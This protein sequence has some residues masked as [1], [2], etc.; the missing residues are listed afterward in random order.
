[1][2]FNSYSF[3]FLFL[4]IAFFGTFWLG[5]IGRR[6]AAIWLGLASLAFY[7]A[8]NYRFVAVL[9]ASIAFN[10]GAGRWIEH[11]RE[12]GGG[13]PGTLS[14]AAPLAANLLVLGYFKYANFFAAT[15]NSILGHRLPELNIVLPLGISFFTFTQIAYL[16]DVYRGI[17]FRYAF[18][19]YLLFVTW[20]PHLI[21][22]PILHH[23]QMTPQFSNPAT[24]RVN[25]ANATVGVS[26][27]VLGLAKKVLIADTLSDYVDNIFSAANLGQAPMLIEAWFGALAYSLQL[28]F[29]FSGYCD[30]AIG[31]S[32][33]FNVRLPANFDS[34]YRASS[35]IDFWR[36][37][38]MTL[39][40]FLRDYL[41]FP[42]GGNRKGTARR[43][44]NLMI[45]MLLGGLWHG[46]SWTFVAWGG[47]HGVYLCVNHG[48]RE[49]KN[50]LGFGFGGMIPSFLAR[51]LTF[52]AVVFAWVLFRAENFPAAEMIMA[53]MTGMNGMLTD[54]MREFLAHWRMGDGDAFKSL[55][56]LFLPAMQRSPVDPREGVITLILGLALVWLCPNV[57]QMMRKHRP[58]WDDLEQTPSPQG[59]KRVSKWLE[60]KPLP[61]HAA[62]LGLLLFWCLISLSKVTQF[63]YWQ[64]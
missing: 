63:L 16:V 6:P 62:A 8:W 44:L 22:G 27:F 13:H 53:G 4:P 18:I 23:Q 41:Y 1:M 55:F 28:Y 3:I 5:R 35:I 17:A 50:R 10:Y 15:V 38:H 37:W 31:A 56:K 43:Y 11:R 45:T 19:D 25:A 9:L 29:D 14:L 7:A 64:F 26:I 59:L 40:A 36:R 58:T 61:L 60:W 46:A 24:Y 49:L 21:A 57:R 48:W 39:S 12:R 2:L 32:L 54:T 30:M 34:P 33:M 20:F 42:L 52:V 51:A 47:L